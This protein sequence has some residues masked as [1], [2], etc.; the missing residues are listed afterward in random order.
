MADSVAKGSPPLP[1][2]VRVTPP[3]LPLPA[4]I[5]EPIIAAGREERGRGLQTAL[6]LL[7][8]APIEEPIIAAGVARA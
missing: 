2:A 5:G 8:P 3:L 7:G 6:G 1:E 4:P